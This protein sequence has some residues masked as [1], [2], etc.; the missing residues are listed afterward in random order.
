MFDIF[1]KKKA[2]SKAA[3]PASQTAV[4]AVYIMTFT[5]KEMPP[6]MLKP[7]V[8]IAEGRFKGKNPEFA[9]LWTE[10]LRPETKIEIANVKYAGPIMHTPQTMQITLANWIK[11]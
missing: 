5:T 1:K 7:T 8:Q 2:E 11:K 3:M 9:R 10:Q 4:K 6:E